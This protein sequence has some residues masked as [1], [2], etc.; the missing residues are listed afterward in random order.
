MFLIF[1]CYCCLNVHLKAIGNRLAQVHFYKKDD[2]R[3]NNAETMETLVHKTSASERNLSGNATS[4]HVQYSSMSNTNAPSQTPQVILSQSAPLAKAAKP[5]L[6]DSAQFVSLKKHQKQNK[7]LRFFFQL[8]SIL[9][10]QFFFPLPLLYLI[11]SI[12]K[13]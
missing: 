1:C 3:H 9:F 2:I 4:S 10:Q 11:L 13:I 5:V 6:R 7:I 8:R 12:G